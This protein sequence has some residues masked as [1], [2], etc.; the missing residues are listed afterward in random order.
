MKN[1]HI[2]TIA[3]ALLVCLAAGAACNV[4]VHAQEKPDF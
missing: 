3:M 4:A 1:K 2:L